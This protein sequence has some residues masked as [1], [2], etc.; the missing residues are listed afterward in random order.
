MRTLGSRAMSDIDP[1]AIVQ[2]VCFAA[3]VACPTVAVIV[4]GLSQRAPD[5]N[6]STAS[7]RRVVALGR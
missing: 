4:N 7:A 6:W 5:R 2:W 1:F 3:V